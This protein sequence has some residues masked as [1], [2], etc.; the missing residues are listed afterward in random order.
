MSIFKARIFQNSLFKQAK[1]LVGSPTRSF[2]CLFVSETG[3]IGINILPM[4][5]GFVVNRETQRVWRMISYLTCT[6]P[7]VEGRLLPVAERCYVPLDPFNHISNKDKVKLSQE[8]TVDEKTNKVILSE[9][10]SIG[11][12]EHD[13]AISAVR[14]SEAK[15]QSAAMFK[16]A[17]IVCGL[18]IVI[19]LTWHFIRK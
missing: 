3:D 10:D 9:L 8:S 5:T 12:R 19:G 1:W 6:I 18:I 14:N 13:K 7:D 15:R 4:N 16:T 11:I 2:K 17:M